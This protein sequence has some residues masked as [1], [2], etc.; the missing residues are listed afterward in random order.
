VAEGSDGSLGAGSKA[1]KQ[2]ANNHPNSPSRD[3]VDELQ[4]KMTPSHS[5]ASITCSVGHLQAAI[6]KPAHRRCSERPVIVRD[7][8]RP[9][10]GIEMTHVAGTGMKA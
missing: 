6:T 4:R 3:G 5:V 9:I 7:P 8:Q 10:L 2:R 1:P